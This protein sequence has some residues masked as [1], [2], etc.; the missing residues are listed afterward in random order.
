MVSDCAKKIVE[1]INNTDKAKTLLKYHRDFINQNFD[2]KNHSK[3][4]KEIIYSRISK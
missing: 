4:L 1:L 3:K 2:I